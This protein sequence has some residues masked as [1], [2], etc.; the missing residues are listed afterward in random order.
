MVVSLKC[1]KYKS[2]TAS[3]AGLTTGGT[4]SACATT[5]GGGYSKR[6]IT[7][8]TTGYRYSSWGYTVSSS[9]TA[10]TTF[11]SSATTTTTS[12]TRN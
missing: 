11:W 6:R 1:Y 10:A 3:N 2:R 7:S 4:G 12:V 9:A 8:A 5:L